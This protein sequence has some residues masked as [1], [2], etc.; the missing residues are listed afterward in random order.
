MSSG[1]TNCG[2]RDCFEIAVSD[3]IGEPE[4]CSACEAAGCMVCD[5]VDKDSCRNQDHRCCADH[6]DGY[7]DDTC[8]D[9]T[10]DGCD[11]TGE[12]CPCNYECHG[13]PIESATDDTGE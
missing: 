4:L 10:L 8:T 2:C 7:D 12:E 11:G 3:D 1:Y 6:D 13:G 5:C 9:C